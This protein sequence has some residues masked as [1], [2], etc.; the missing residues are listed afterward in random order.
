MF[1]LA[2]HA[3]PSAFLLAKLSEL[4]TRLEAGQI[5]ES[6]FTARE[7]EL[8]DQLDQCQAQAAGPRPGAEEN[9]R[10]F[11]SAKPRTCARK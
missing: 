10:R 1:Q 8:R 3:P 4:Y 11:G 6:E 2:K 7:I 5:S 9:A